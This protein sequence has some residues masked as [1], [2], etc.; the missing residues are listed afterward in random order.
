MQLLHELSFTQQG[1]N[2]EAKFILNSKAINEPLDLC[3]H[4]LQ[5]PNL[6]LSGSLSDVFFCCTKEAEEVCWVGPSCG[7]VCIVMRWW[8]DK[9]SLTNILRFNQMT[10][11]SAI[12][13]VLAVSR[14]ESERSGKF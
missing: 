3:A 7:K 4:S 13:M 9:R 12:M 5:P 10:C 8:P 2:A 6:P 14:V 1:T 11:T